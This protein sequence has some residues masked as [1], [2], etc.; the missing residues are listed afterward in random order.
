ME[1]TQFTYMQQVGG[2]E[3]YLVP[4]EIAYGLERIAMIIQNIDNLQRYGMI[5]E[6]HMVIYLNNVSMSFQNYH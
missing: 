5:L 6:Q 4:G 1:I 3:C 2:I